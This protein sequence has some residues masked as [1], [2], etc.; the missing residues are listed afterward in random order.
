MYEIRIETMK[1]T[2][3]TFIYALIGLFA[4]SCSS[5]GNGISDLKI[6]GSDEGVSVGQPSLIE[7][8][9]NVEDAIDE[10]QITWE[11]TSGDGWQLAAAFTDGL[12]GQ[13]SVRFSEYIDVPVD[14]APGKYRLTM[15][16]KQQDGTEIEESVDAT[17]TID[18]T[19]PVASDLDVGINAAGND[20]H[21]ETELTAV[22]KIQQVTVQ[23][24]GA[25]WSK[26]FTFDGS[27]IKDQLSLHFHEHVHIDEAPA[28]NYQVVL[29]VE[30]QEGRSASVEGS[31]TKK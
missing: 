30:D 7:A 15:K 17:L 3:L 2:R 22:K 31:F 12:Q 21:L 5:K 20:L 18:S 27:R 19:V 29:T 9:I 23:V 28:G 4:V 25:A 26:D 1:K 11:P 6:V 10:V 24:N 16:V 14:A 8:D 13:Q